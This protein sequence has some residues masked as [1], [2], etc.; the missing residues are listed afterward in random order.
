M[1]IYQEKLI[2]A[3]RE[4]SKKNSE[5]KQSDVLAHNQS[6]QSII[7]ALRVLTDRELYDNFVNYGN[8]DGLYLKKILYALAAVFTFLME[9]PLKV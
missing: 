3:D 1:F 8:P 6:K 5:Y 9:L 2:R 7:L 4:N